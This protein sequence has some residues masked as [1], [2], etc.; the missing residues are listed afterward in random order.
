MKFKAYYNAERFRYIHP[1]IE[2]SGEF[3]HSGGALIPKTGCFMSE[4]LDVYVDTSDGV[5][6]DLKIQEYCGRM[7]ACIRLSKG[8]KMLFFK[9]AHSSKW[10][11]DIEDMAQ[12]N[13]GVVVPFFK[14]SFNSDF[15]SK[16]IPNISRIRGASRREDCDIGIFADLN[17]RY[18]YPKPSSSN[19]IIS[20]TDHR[21]FNLP[22]ASTN[23]GEYE[24]S[25]RP[26]MLSKVQASKLSYRSASLAYEKYIESSMSCSSVL[27]PPGIGEYTSRIMDQAACGNLIILRKNSYDNGNSWKDYIPEI[28]FSKQD[29]EDDYRNVLADSVLWKEKTLY[30]YEKLWSPDAVYQYFV[31][32]IKKEL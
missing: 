8:K 7:L 17:K 29:W 20:N 18:T 30:Y 32:H 16:L 10:S 19:A 31:N 12:K 5:N 14:W 4:D 26:D 1:L 13:N 22:G 27:N 11:R 9:A 23:T 21:K 24:I 3:Q 6:D 15:Y 2:S 25:S 28:D